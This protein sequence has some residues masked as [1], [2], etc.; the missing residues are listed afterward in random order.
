MKKLLSDVLVASFTTIVL[1]S[2]TGSAYSTLTVFSLMIH[3]YKIISCCMFTDA[4]KTYGTGPV[5]I[6]LR[7]NWAKLYFK[8]RY[9]MQC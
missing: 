1:P 3:Q 4:W 5:T 2:S 6:A 9:S 8:K 7:Y